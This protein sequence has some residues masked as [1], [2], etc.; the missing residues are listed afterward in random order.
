[1]ATYLPGT[2][3]LDLLAKFRNDNESQRNLV[4][5]FTNAEK[6]FIDKTDDNEMRMILTGLPPMNDLPS[7]RLALQDFFRRPIGEELPHAISN[8][9]AEVTPRYYSQERINAAATQYVKFLREELAVAFPEFQE[10]LQAL[11]NLRLLDDDRLLRK[12]E[13]IM[14]NKIEISGSVIGFLNTGE[15]ED[16]RNI[17]INVSALSDVGNN[18]LAMAFKEITEAVSRNSEITQQQRAELL[19]LVNELSKQAT[20]PPNERSSKSVIKTIFTGISTGIGTVAALA[21]IWSTW[22]GNILKFFGL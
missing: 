3:M 19:E 13:V 1:M 4:R 22:S 2:S 10:K 8:A 16:V 11:A 9:I 17:S 18:D 5:A 14:G 12:D 15:I 21:Q 20:L 6:R 7:I